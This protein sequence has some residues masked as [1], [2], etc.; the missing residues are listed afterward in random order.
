MTV[1]RMV[2]QALW[3]LLWCA[4]PAMAQQDAEGSKDHPLV[5]RMAGF[6]I[7][8]ASARD[9]DAFEF[10]ISADSEQRVEGRYWKIEYWLREGAKTPS[11]L[12]ISRN[13]ENAFSAKGGRVRFRESD[14]AET[15]LVLPQGTG[16]LWMHIDVSNAGETYT[17]TIVERAG[18]TQQVALTA[19]AIADALKTQGSIAL[20]NI[21]FDTGKA[22]LRPESAAELALV[23]EVLKA[24]PALRLEVQGHT[25]NTGT[26]AA[27]LT[28][29]QQRAAAVRD[30][31]VTT[32]GIAAARLTSAGFGDTKPVA[33]NDTD[34]GRALNRRVELVRR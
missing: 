28:L 21:L 9:F 17:L 15:T 27:N 13:Y 16:E 32:G 25:D 4:V 18:M 34:A 8:D 33:P 22:T 20:R 6:Y 5:P 1:R 7:S 14:A 31:L 26:A 30:Y 19:A 11:P 10:P 23:V 24:D 29:S 2:V 3:V 12:E